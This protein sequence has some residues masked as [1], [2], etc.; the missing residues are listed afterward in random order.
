MIAVDF[1]ESLLVGSADKD[2]EL[3]RRNALLSSGLIIVGVLGIALILCG[4]TGL[5]VDG[6]GGVCLGA[7]GFA[8]CYMS[9]PAYMLMVVFPLSVLLFAAGVLGL[10]AKR[11]RRRT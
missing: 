11:F 4:L 1:S 10:A 3:F 8:Y 5:R 6:W 2:P 9:Q 7:G